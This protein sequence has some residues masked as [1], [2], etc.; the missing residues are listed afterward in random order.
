[1]FYF[2][3]NSTVKYDLQIKVL[4]ILK[5][6]KKPDTLIPKVQILFGLDI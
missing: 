1:M 6:K 2:W 5:Q 3:L 4:F